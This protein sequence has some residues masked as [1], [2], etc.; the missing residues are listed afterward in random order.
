M[1]DAIHQNALAA[2]TDLCERGGLELDG[3]DEGLEEALKKRLAPRARNL[4][5]ALRGA[6]TDD[7]VRCLFEVLQ[8]YV[9]MF[10]ATLAFFERAGATEGRE[11]W[12]IQIDEIDLDLDHFRKFLRKWQD[13]ECEI[14]V[15]A[16]DSSGAWTFERSSRDM[17]EMQ[18]VSGIP[19]YRAYRSSA[20]DVSE[21][22]Q[23]YWAGHYAPL[24]ASLL[25]SR[26]GPGYAD[27]AG[28]AVVALAILREGWDSRD[29]LLADYRSR[30]I[31]LDAADALDP[32]TIA[33]NETDFWLGTLV[34]RLAH[35]QLIPREQKEEFDRRL[36]QAFAAWPRKKFGVRLTLAEL[37]SFLSLPIWKKRYELYAVW[38]ATEIVEALAGHDVRIHH[39]NG[40]IVFAF[41]ETIVATV[42]STRPTVRLISERRVPLAAP[43]GKGR[44]GHAQPDYG[45]WRQGSGS[46]TC[47]L[48]VEVKHYKRA[49]RTAFGDV[50]DDYA[51][52]F[53]HAKIFLVNHG[54]IGDVFA[55]RP[56]GH[57]PRCRAIEH[58]TAGHLAARQTLHSAVRD[59]VGEPVRRIAKKSA[60]DGDTI[61][62]VDVS[63]SMTGRFADPAF[64][65]I[66]RDIVDDRVTQAAAIDYRIFRLMPL[67][68]IF[69]AVRSNSGGTTALK[70]PISELL[71]SHARVLLITD[72]G[73][74]AD[75][76]GLAFKVLERRPDALSVVEISS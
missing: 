52:A 75:L 24:P 5:P 64:E 71:Q 33:Q 36:Q 50:L 74:V 56:G 48:V 45:L 55:S 1:R 12:N 35:A 70:A 10:R 39:E 47:G 18:G 60:G 6:S 4:E 43:V 2:W 27:A 37:E 44:T 29:A 69:E 63:G 68:E 30:R 51:R 11:Q 26:L 13:I 54:P 7:L 14:E 42:E 59:Y 40:K 3:R 32:G 72:D 22:L 57:V 41:R 20:A 76:N 19:D 73:G 46:D 49:V 17:P 25:P 65:S 23:A 58:L 8:P 66:V 67:D 38:I 61:L 34:A 21:W 9:Q 16:L 62:A 31:V 28:H 53:P 15:P